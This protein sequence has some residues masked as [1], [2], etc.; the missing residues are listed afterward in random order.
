MYNGLSKIN[1]KEAL[2]SI[3]NYWDPLTVGNHNGQEI[4]LIKFQGE[5]GWYT[6]EED[7][8][9]YLLDGHLR[10]EYRDEI[11]ELEPH[12]FIVIPMGIERRLI[13]SEVVSVM[14]LEPTAVD[15]KPIDLHEARANFT[16]N[17][18]PSSGTK[19]RG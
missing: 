4:K 10:I 6:H 5:F 11:I 13:A 2:A 14:M 9:F 16:S 3:D 8:L 1:I 19:T 7:E 15:E 12:E 17:V 18:C